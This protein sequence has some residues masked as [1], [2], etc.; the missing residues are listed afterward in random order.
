M[1]DPLIFL[2]F[3]LTKTLTFK[4]TYFVP[5]LFTELGIYEIDIDTIFQ[6]WFNISIN[7]YL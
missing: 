3:Y 4:Y 5:F 1:H 2:L 7:R 6:N